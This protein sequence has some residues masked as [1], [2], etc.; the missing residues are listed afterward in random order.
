MRVQLKTT[1]RNKLVMATSCLALGMFLFGPN[2]LALAQIV[3][4]D[5]ECPIVVGVVTCT[6]DLSRGISSSPSTQAITEINIENTTTPIAPAGYFGIGVV[7][8]NSDVTINVADDVVINTYDDPGINGF[9]QGIIG[10]V[11]NGFDMTLNSGATITADGNGQAGVGIEVSNISGNGTVRI[12]NTGDITATTSGESA[13]AISSFNSGVSDNAVIVN[14]GNLVATSGATGERDGTTA[15]IIATNQNGDSIIDIT[16]TGDITVTVAENSFDTD[17]A[18]IAAGIVTNTFGA[19]SSTTINNSGAITVNGANTRGIVGF[20]QNTTAATASTMDI[21]NSGVITINGDGS[22]GILLQQQGTGTAVVLDNTGAITI[23]GDSGAGIIYLDESATGGT[24]VLGNT[25]AIQLNGD[26]SSGIGA[27]SINAGFDAQFSGTMTNSGNINGTAS[28]IGLALNS[29]NSQA[30]NAGLTNT[31]MIDFASSTNL[32]TAG[33]SV[34]LEIAS[35]QADSVTQSTAVVDNSGDIAIGTGNAI[36]TLADN[37]SLTNTGSLSTT[38]DS[39]SLI[40]VRAPVADMTADIDLQ[41]GVLTTDGNNSAGV[42]ILPDTG[43]SGTDITLTS[44]NTTIE[45]RGDGAHGINI[46]DV[47]TDSSMGS[48]IKARPRPGL[49][50]GDGG[51]GNSFTFDMTGG[52]IETLGADAYGL[53]IGS[54]WGSAGSN[55]NIVNIAGSITAASNALVTASTVNLLTIGAT[56]Q[57]T[58]SAADAIVAVQGSG[59][60]FERLENSGSITAPSGFAILADLQTDFDDVIINM[61]GG[62]IGGNISLGGGDDVFDGRAGS[63]YGGEIFAGAGNDV[64][65]FASDALFGNVFMG[66]GD[67]VL[68]L[69]GMNIFNTLSGGDGNDTLV[70]TTQAGD[71]LVLVLDSATA[72][73]IEG[74]EVFNQEGPGQITFEGSNNIS[75]Q[76]NLNGGTLI[77][78]AG[79]GNVNVDAAAGTILGGVGTLGDVRINDGGTLSPGGTDIGTLNLTSLFLSAGANLRFDLGLPDIIG[80][81]V[82]DL[83]E[84][85]GDLTLDGVLDIFS[86]PDFGQGVYRLFNYGG[87]L[88]DNGLE[89]GMAPSETYTVQTGVAGQI[90]LLVGVVNLQFWDPVGP[91]DGT[92][93]GGDGVWGDGGTNWANSDGTVNGALNGDFAIFMGDA[94]TVTV[95]G[96]RSISGMQVVTDGYSFVAGTGGQLSLDAA[97]NVFRVDPGATATL[98]VPLVGDGR[99]VKRDSGTLILTGTNTNAGGMEVREGVIEISSD[100]NLGAAGAT[101]VFGGGT[102]RTGGAMTLARDFEVTN[103]GGILDDGGNDVGIS[104]AFT[105]VGTLTKTGTGTLTLSGDSSGFGGEFALSAGSLQLD[106]ILAGLLDVQSGATLGGTGTAGDL[107]I[108]GILAVGASIGTLTTTGDVVFRLGSDFQVEL[109]ADGSGDFLD[110]GGT[111]TIEGGTLSI[112]TLDPDTVYT[113]GQSYTILSAAGGLSGQFDQLVETSAFLDFATDYQANDLLVTIEQVLTFPDVANTFNQ[114]QASNSLMELGQTQGS[115]SLAVY[116]ALLVLDANSARSA[117]DL[118]SGEIYAGVVEASQRQGRA[119]SDIMLSQSWRNGVDGFVAWGSLSVQDGSVDLDGN[120][121]DLDFNRQ[122]IDLGIGYRGEDNKYLIGVTTGWSNGDV[123][124]DVRNSAADVDSWQVGAYGR[125][126]TG[127]AG[128]SAGAAINIGN[129]NADVARNISFPGI[130][131]TATSSTDTNTT[132]LAAEARYGKKLGGGNWVAGP[133]VSVS[134]ANTDLERFGETGAEALNL[135]GSAETKASVFGAGAFA[136]WQGDKGFFDASVQYGNSNNDGG[137]A[138][139][140]LDGAAG[141]PFLVRAAQ[142]DGDRAIFKMRGAIDFGNDW[143]L[144]ASARAEWAS[145]DTNLSA[146]LT[147]KKT[148]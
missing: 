97:E 106:G 42:D 104:G 25:G 123:T 135:S 86:T 93:S 15:G 125:L 4:G 11:S 27:T 65:T 9:A 124:L 33:I 3:P 60:G 12:N 43:S 129:G 126:G 95:E 57:I 102:L 64:F 37:I 81:G 98:D 68:N 100:D 120:G 99:L 117:F 101:F 6:G 146:G 84:I 67:D 59:A 108:S 121:A 70:Y 143:S 136:N 148:F 80:G 83:V 122:G 115:D 141:T 111:A 36:R 39:S 52:S 26:S 128:L 105:G 56:G 22:Q 1:A 79:L 18:G 34:N 87:T 32:S 78:D 145:K 54:G 74:W 48:S 76:Y 116:N 85:A 139:L 118:S 14:S 138:S 96:T 131:R 38:G 24:F 20:T 113:D 53:M 51:T 71:N 8:D 5:P 89:I 31:G 144:A 112:I 114:S 77:V 2:Q 29:Y 10:V 137:Q 147:V 45:T 82:N 94:G 19:Q 92:I 16:N 13:F 134:Y 103:L 63:L 35:G 46:G 140:T 72:V 142:Q 40:L 119:Q 66:D 21:T 110:V 58:S 133:V 49:N 61:D 62:T 91:A 23:N 130:N 44:A 132:A 90:N 75:A 107:D 73:T 7:S 69:F 88:T 17:F 109:A 55:S 30:S 41:G 47:G 50:A 127:R 28:G